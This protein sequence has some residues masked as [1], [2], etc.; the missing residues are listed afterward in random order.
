MNKRHELPLLCLF[1]VISLSIVS[2]SDD[3]SEKAEAP[4]TQAQEETSAPDSTA[5]QEE[6]TAE[7]DESDSSETEESGSAVDFAAAYDEEC[8]SGKNT[9]FDCEVLR[10]LLVVEVA[11]ALEEI[12]R[13]GDQRGTEEALAA[14][15]LVDEPE[16]LIA[17]CRILGHFPDTPGIAEKVTPLL[18]DSPYLAVEQTA[19]QL[20]SRNADPA[21]AGM[22][23]QWSANHGLMWT[24][25]PY[26]LVPDFPEHYFDMEFPEYPDAEWYSPADSDR[27]VGWWV[28]RSPAEVSKWFA[29]KL[30]VEVM[31]Y[32]QWVERSSAEMTTAYQS[33]MSQAGSGETQQLMEKYVQTQDPALL[34]KIQQLQAEM[35]V[36][37]QKLQKDSDKALNS[38]LL[39][40]GGVAPED[41]YYLIA[42][43]KDGHVARAILVYRHT[44]AERT[45]MQMA[46]DLG[47]Y[48]PA[49]PVAN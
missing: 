24:D 39:P 40:P 42:E 30:G 26:A 23:S 25:D 3:E 9:S 1:L 46:W 29:E 32:N 7:E 14:L 12:E 10:S 13:S 44:G 45:V 15:D 5:E 20:L 21:T 43:E 34:E 41:V 47:D 37:S 18:L 8:D 4:A 33:L 19:A 36:V 48:P 22:A 28:Q 16:I 27:S 6:L 38:L 49:W 17:A 2:C 31:D 35:E 11:M